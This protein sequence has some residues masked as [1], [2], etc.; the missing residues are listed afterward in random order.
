MV[1]GIDILSGLG[2]FIGGLLFI[3]GLAAFLCLHTL[4]WFTSY[5]NLAQITGEIIKPNIS[6][7]NLV[8]MHA[9]ISNACNQS[10]NVTIPIDEMGMNLTLS[11]AEIPQA[12][13]DIPQLLVAKVFEKLYY[14]Q[15]GCEFLDCVKN[16]K[17][18][19]QML[20]LVSSKA[21]AFYAQLEIYSIII[22]ILGFLLVCISSRRIKIITRTIGSSLLIVSIGAIAIRYIIRYLPLPEEAL[23]IASG[24]SVKIY[25]VLEPYIWAFLAVGIILLLISIFV[26]TKKEKEEEEWQAEEEEAEIIEEAEE[27]A[28]A[29]KKKGKKKVK[30]S[31]E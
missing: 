9:Y 22:S 14:K 31:E 20:F 2:K 4:V 24:I 13:E 30:E 11:C 23:Q 25:G 27:E 29:I 19:E 12:K 6:E 21:N 28:K 5:E 7:E 15:Y 8:Q 26:K 1:K 10:Q 16:L 17:G 18:Q 3:I